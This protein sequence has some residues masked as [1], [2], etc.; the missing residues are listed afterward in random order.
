VA[1]S[2]TRAIY[3]HSADRKVP[4][5]MEHG[6]YKRA[7]PFNTSLPAKRTVCYPNYMSQEASPPPQNNTT[8][9]CFQCTLTWK[10]FITVT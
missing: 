9:K 3:S 8:N 2:G 1:A 7:I 10:T 4:V 6:V 5:A